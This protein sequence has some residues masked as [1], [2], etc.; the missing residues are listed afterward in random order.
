MVLK[1][2]EFMA[3]TSVA[4]NRLTASDMKLDMSDQPNLTFQKLTPLNEKYYADATHCGNRCHA[5]HLA[6]IW[7]SSIVFAKH[8]QTD[9]HVCA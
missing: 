5:K 6:S 1:M 2:L 8:H 9:Q 7:L 3:Y 4:D